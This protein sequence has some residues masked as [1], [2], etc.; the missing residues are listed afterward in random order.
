MKKNCKHQWK[1]DE[2]LASGAIVLVC[3]SPSDLG[4]ETRVACTKCGKV[5]YVRVKDLGSIVDIYKEAI[6]DD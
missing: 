6:N 1:E 5:E 3:G 2:M 4:E